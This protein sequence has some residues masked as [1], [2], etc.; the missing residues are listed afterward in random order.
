MGEEGEALLV[1]MERRQQQIPRWQNS[2]WGTVIKR[3][4][5]RSR[6]YVPVCL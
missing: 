1:I 2:R 6:K 4:C 5:F 3:I